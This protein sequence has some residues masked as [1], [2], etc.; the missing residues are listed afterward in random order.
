MA[1]FT[2]NGYEKRSASEIKTSL[3]SFMK[4]NNA[5]YQELSADVQNNLLDTSAATISEVENAV[6]SLA[7]SFGPSFQGD[8][9]FMWEQQA[10]SMG[11]KYK[12]ATKSKVT[13]KFTGDPGL[14]IPANTETKYGYKTDVSITLDTTGTGY[15]SASSD[16]ESVYA[17]GTIDSVATKVSDTL[18]VTNPSATIPS[19]PEETN[20][21]LRIRSQRT[22]RSPRIG[23]LDYALLQLTSLEGVQERLCNFNFSQTTLKRGIEVIVG[24]G[25]SNEV[26]N[27]IFKSFFDIGNIVSDPSDGETNRTS[28]FTVNYYGSPINIVWTLPKELKLKIRVQ[29]AFRYVNVYSGTLESQ[30][31]TRF[32]KLLNN[33]KVGLPLNKNLL[34]SLI[35]EEVLKLGIDLQYL[36]SITYL[37]NDADTD[38]SL[39]FDGYN[40]LAAIKKDVYTTLDEFSL[41]I[42]VE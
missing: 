39:Q 18:T 42:R 24:G 9:G 27:A 19:Q 17:A 7:N 20:D 34:D 26:A 32:E 5:T 30:V 1:G 36:Q 16:D 40:Y 14:Y 11:L 38:S 21:E 22:I 10:A 41:S 2:S 15:V 25:N 29:V 6:S 28:K 31:Q 3:V 8:N 4:R 33:R 37:I 23:G 13:L 35:Y 12:D